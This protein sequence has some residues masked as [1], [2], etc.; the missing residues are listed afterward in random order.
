MNS[1]KHQNMAI[2]NEQSHQTNMKD[3]IEVIFRRKGF[4]LGFFVLTIIL[5][6]IGTGLTSPVYQAKALIRIDLPE[7]SILPSPYPSQERMQ[8][9]ET[10][11][12]ILKSLPVLTKTVE[13]LDL[14]KPIVSMP[15]TL[16]K[17][18]C[19]QLKEISL[20]VRHKQVELQ[21][22]TS[23]KAQAVAQLKKDVH[24]IPLIH[25]NL[26]EIQ[27]QAKDPQRAADIAQTIIQVYIESHFNPQSGGLKKNYNFIETQLRDA[28]EQLHQAEQVLQAFIAKEGIVLFDEEIQMLTK[29]LA[30]VQKEYVDIKSKKEE[31]TAALRIN[32]DEYDKI[33]MV[34]PD[35]NTVSYMTQLKEQLASLEAQL[36]QYMSKYTP[37]G[38]FVQRVKSDIATLKIT[39][40]EEALQIIHAKINFLTARE[41]SLLEVITDYKEKLTRAS[42]TSLTSQ[43]LK[44]DVANKRQIHTM[45][46]HKS[47][48]IRLT[49]AMKKDE[50]SN[51]K[52]IR[53]ISQAMVPVKPIKPSWPMNMA[54]A[55]VIG[56][57]GSLGSVFFIDYCD[58]TIKNTKDIPV[59]LH[60]EVL[61]SI[62]FFKIHALEKIRQGAQ[63]G[64]E[65][66]GVSLSLC[67][68]PNSY[69][70]VLV[71]SPS[72]EGK[73]T[74]AIFL[75]TMIAQTNSQKKVALVE[76]NL[77]TPS[78]QTRLK[79][80]GSMGLT[81]YL[82]QKNDL[83]SCLQNTHLDNFKVLTSTRIR[84]NQ[85]ALSLFESVLFE[86]LLTKLEDEFDMVIIDSPAL[87][88]YADGFILGQKVQGTLFVVEPMKTRYVVAKYYL[89]R[90]E[91]AKA[92]ILGIMLNKRKFFIPKNIYKKFYGA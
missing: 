1:I 58:D 64:L 3:I 74:V 37:E 33:I 90:L 9:I 12:L 63:Q 27:A 32:H 87:N 61:G 77:R 36:S 52:D 73:T 78:I 40:K 80:T 26:I 24:I 16:V 39:I 30:E 88:H 82:M 29:N 51:I 53:L 21:T 67:M 70:S 49:D 66:L 17:K 23:L 31:I 41:E 2:H 89:E 6:V 69:K 57:M 25:T 20:K 42:A 18:F 43:R 45:L 86:E 54:L 22:A 92:Q 35:I 76:A 83:A 15:S 14:D 34:T 4:V 48:E 71:S 72:S 59:K 28:A 7:T 81:D 44:E 85:T 84:D 19:Q 11:S 50:I 60:Y 62:P 46:L 47:N 10:E 65:N 5:F 8:W 55:I 38:V 79:L 75:A 56:M 68:S 13:L 91:K